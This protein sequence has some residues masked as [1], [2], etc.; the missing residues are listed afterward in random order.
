MSNQNHYQKIHQLLIIL[1]SNHPG[2]AEDIAEI[3]NI[4]RR[5]LFRYMEKLRDH[6]AKIEYC[7]CRKTYFL[8]NQFDFFEAFFKNAL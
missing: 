4:S 1:E 8:K 2:T 5:T 6:G 3:L 7:K